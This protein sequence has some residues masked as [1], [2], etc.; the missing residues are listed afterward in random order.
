MDVTPDG[1]Y[2]EA[3]AE[4]FVRAATGRDVRT[5]SSVL[6]HQLEYLMAVGIA[7]SDGHEFKFYD[8]STFAGTPANVDDRVIAGDAERVLGIREDVALEVLEA[9][10]EYLRAKGLT[11]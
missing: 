4:R 1:K 2:D 3:E 10:F 8:P 9:E 7:E 5:V 6:A 11:G